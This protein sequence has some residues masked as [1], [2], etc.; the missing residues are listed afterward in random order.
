MIGASLLRAAGRSQPLHNLL[1]GI[2]DLRIVGDANPLISSLDF[3]SRRVGPGAL[4]TALPGADFDGHAYIETAVANGAVAVL[5]EHPV[6]VVVPQLIVPDS[7]ASLAQIATVFYGDPSLALPTIGITGTDG[8]T[9]TSYLLERI[10][11]YAGRK[12]GVIG[13]VGIRIGTDRTFDLGHQTTPESNL[14][15]AFLREMADSQVDNAIIEATSHGLAMHRLDETHFRIA[16]VT[17]ITHEHLE[18]HK[19]LDRYRRAKAILIERTAA[20]GGVIVLNSDDDGARSMAPWA[21][22]GDVHWY[23]MSDE[24]A[25][26]RA[27]NIVFNRTSLTFDLSIFDITHPVLLP[28]IGDFNVSNA[29]CAA[30]LAHA[31]GI[32]ASTIAEALHQ[33]IEIPGRLHVL[34]R[35]QPFSVVV[36][37]AH[38]PESLRKILGLLRSLHANGRIIVVTGSAGERDPGKRPLQGAVCSQLADFSIFTSEDPRNEDPDRII[39]EIAVGARSAGGVEGRDFSHVTDR[40]QAIADAFAMATEGDCVLLAGK[41][42]ETSIIWGFKH[43]PWNEAEVAVELLAARGFGNPA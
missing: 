4:F 35:G 29:L 41:G 12:T 2:R 16:G 5:C 14:V 6:E 20:T 36:D 33:P 9:T 34:E 13:T 10:L 23:S 26:I 11:Q 17:N 37:Y 18:F 25:Q 43:V 38:T 7:R 22:G 19:T 39:D 31:S 30:G 3:D 32:A 28:M 1:D 27:S 8:K 40:R 24:N 42:H 21:E 15:Q